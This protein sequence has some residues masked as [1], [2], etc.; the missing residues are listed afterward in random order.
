MDGL[1]SL[2]AF[3]FSTA[4]SFILTSAVCAG[5]L[6]F[7][8][9]LNT[10]FFFLYQT[11]SFIDEMNWT[12]YGSNL[13][14]WPAAASDGFSSILGLWAPLKMFSWCTESRAHCALP[15]SDLDCKWQAADIQPRER[16]NSDGMTRLLPK[17]CTAE[18]IS[19]WG[20]SLY[21]YNHHQSLITSFGVKCWTNTNH[22]SLSVIYLDITSIQAKLS[23]RLKFHMGA[24][25][26]MV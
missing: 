14:K 22:A 2:T 9:L 24:V 11:A 19:H 10:A 1:S 18:W 17:T 4:R 26:L 5:I 6:F 21:H 12:K 13:M 25:L 16:I 15:H 8:S 20:R 23:N 3:R 7:F